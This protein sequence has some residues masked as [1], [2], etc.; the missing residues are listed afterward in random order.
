MLPV[1]WPGD[2]LVIDRA[3][4]DPAVEGDI[5]IFSNGRRLVAHRVTKSNG[6]G[7]TIQ[8][9]G[10]ALSVPDSPVAHDELLGKVSFIVRKGKLVKPA[11]S[12]RLSERAV[13]AVFRRSSLAARVVVGVHG[14]RR[15]PQV[16][17]SL[18]QTK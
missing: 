8:T 5:V 7:S 12:L 17:A 2:T 11:R 10:D 15:T 18:V 13:A 4:G 6:S 3:N 14:L 16:Y 1:I 9:Q